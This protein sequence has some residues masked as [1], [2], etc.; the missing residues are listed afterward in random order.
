M[1][2]KEDDVYGKKKWWGNGCKN[3]IC[4]FNFGASFIWIFIRELVLGHG[5]FYSKF[6]NIFLYYMD[7]YRYL[8][9]I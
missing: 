9:S 4:F 3:F 1:N 5:F 6:S 2:N 8:H 7:F